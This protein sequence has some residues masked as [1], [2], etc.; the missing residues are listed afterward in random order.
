MVR[1]ISKLFTSQL[2]PEHVEK[3]Q[4]K[5]NEL[6]KRFESA[7]IEGFFKSDTHLHIIRVSQ[8]AELI[9]KEL[10]LSPN[11]IYQVKAIAPFHDIGKLAINTNIIN[12]SSKL[13]CEEFHEIQ[14]H[15]IEGYKLLQ[16]IKSEHLMEIASIVALEHHEKWN[17]EGYPFEKKREE[18]HLYSRIIAAADVLESLSAKRC[19]KQ[20]WDKDRI[21]SLFK[22]QREKH[23]DPRITEVV[24]KNLNELLI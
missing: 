5:I 20:A 18:I 10:N 7:N 23:F 21:Y 13:T 11:D 9:A 3:I 8:I 14:K 19:Y 1:E 24:L 22:E 2:N 17:G 16:E 15:S 6:I 4:P 12:K